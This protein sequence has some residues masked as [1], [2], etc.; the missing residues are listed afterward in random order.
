MHGQHEGKMPTR[1]IPIRD[2]VSDTVCIPMGMHLGAPSKPCVNKGDLVKIG[3]VIGEPVG[4][5]LCMRASPARSRL[6]RNASI[7]AQL[8]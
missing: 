5:C 3:Q 1:N 6:W 4:G 8:P 7:W 2:F